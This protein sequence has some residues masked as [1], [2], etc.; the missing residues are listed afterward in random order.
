MHQKLQ[1]QS[2]KPKNLKKAVCEES[3]PY[4]VTRAIETVIIKAK[5]YSMMGNL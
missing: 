4:K 1:K 2:I 3:P 5:A